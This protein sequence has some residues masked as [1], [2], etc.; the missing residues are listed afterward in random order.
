MT[1][2]REFGWLLAQHAAETR[3]NPCAKLRRLPSGLLS[4][5]VAAAE[6]GL[7]IFVRVVGMAGLNVCSVFDL[8]LKTKIKRG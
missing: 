7:G 5:S 4:M 3:L 2:G 8:I 6:N 1:L